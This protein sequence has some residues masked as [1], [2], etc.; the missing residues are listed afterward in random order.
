MELNDAQKKTVA[1]WV[2]EKRGIADIQKLLASEFKLPMTYLDTRFLLLDLGLQ[3][4]DKEVKAR[5]SDLL[6]GVAKGGEENG[7][8]ADAGLAGP[9][10]VSVALDKVV[11][12]GAMVSGTVTFSDGTKASWMLDQMGRLAID[13]GK[14]GYRPSKEDLEAFQV[15]VSRELQKHG[16]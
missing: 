4:G 14:R 5:G 10:G 13:A 7:L 16:F 12:A 1:Q 8:G 6:G 2:A 15:E 3:I 9:G 11:R